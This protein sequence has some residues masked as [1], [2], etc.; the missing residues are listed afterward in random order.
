[1]DRVQ[2]FQV[3]AIDS[4]AG[5]VGIQYFDGT[6][7]E[8]PLVHWHALDIE[9]CEPPQDW[10]GSFDGS[11]RDENDSAGSMMT[12]ED[13]HEPLEGPRNARDRYLLSD[14]HHAVHPSAKHSQRKRQLTVKH[15][16]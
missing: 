9:S 3:I 5:S 8:W 6:I 1:M 2:A 14:E 15:V 7:D 16:N 12:P 10:T 13:W 4:K 11:D